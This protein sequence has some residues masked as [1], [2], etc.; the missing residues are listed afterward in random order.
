MSDD[1]TREQ[2][3]E[4]AAFLR[5]THGISLR[6]LAGRIGC[7]PSKAGDYADVHIRRF[8]VKLAGQYGWKVS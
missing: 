8:L 4:A 2:A 3:K 6:M 5:R 7:S 1:P